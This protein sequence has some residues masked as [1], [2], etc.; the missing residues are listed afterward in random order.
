[1]IRPLSS[2]ALIGIIAAVTASVS[3]SAGCRN[4]E[5]P[6][7]APVAA[8][9]PST[10]DVPQEI[11]LNRKGMALVKTQAYDEALREFTQAIEKYPNFIQ[12][13]SNRAAVFVLQKKYDKAMDDLKKAFVINPNNP[14]VHYNIAALY[15]L[16][17]QP[18]R[19]LVSLDRALELGFNDYAFLLQD[20]DLNN[21]R[22]QKNFQKILAKHHVPLSK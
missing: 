6:Q 21:V 11:L 10:E 17:N 3:L 5:Q 1:M 19:A 7:P 18:D 8:T 13:Y 20:P 12:S 9:A 2:I 4:K 16:Q 14:S 15:S 22:K